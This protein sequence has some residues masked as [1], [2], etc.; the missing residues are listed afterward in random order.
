M[1][2]LSF[3]NFTTAVLTNS[4]TVTIFVI[5]TLTVESEAGRYGRTISDID[6]Y[7]SVGSAA[8]ELK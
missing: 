7:T 4:S 1:W 8:D 3:K 2:C 5:S 6:S